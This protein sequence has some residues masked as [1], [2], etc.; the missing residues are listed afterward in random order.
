MVSS[1]GQVKGIHT[2]KRSGKIRLVTPDR[3]GYFRLGIHNGKKAKLCGIHRLV[4]ETFLEKIEGKDQ[5]NHKD[6]NKQNNHVENLEW[7]NL[8]ENRRH[9][10]DIGLQKVPRGAENAN[11]KLTEKQVCEI[12]KK[13]IPRKCTLAV[14][15][16]EYNVA[17]Q[18]IS[19]IVNY[20]R[21]AD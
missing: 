2:T 20:Q 7:C 1:F 16:K 5:V 9:A 19:K 8:T 15:A 11:A 12:R 10:Y 6:G 4:A 3:D 18:T 21:Y 13:Y 14:L 17:F